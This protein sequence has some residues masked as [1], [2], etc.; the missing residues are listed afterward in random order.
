MLYDV[1]FDDGDEEEGVLAGRVRRPGQGPPALRTGL[2]V[3][4]KLARKGKVGKRSK[5]RNGVYH[6]Q[7]YVSSYGMGPFM[8]PTNCLWLFT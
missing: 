3:D 5:P 8:C 6:G 2:V 1:D 4:V 7:R